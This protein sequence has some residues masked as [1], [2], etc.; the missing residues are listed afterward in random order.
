M[1]TTL[2]HLKEQYLGSDSELANQTIDGLKRHFP[3]VTQREFFE[4]VEPQEWY[5][6]AGDYVEYAVLGAFLS[7]GLAFLAVFS[8]FYI[9]ILIGGGLVAI[10]G[11]IVFLVG[12]VI[13]LTYLVAWVL[14]ETGAIDHSYIDTTL[15][16]VFDDWIESLGAVEWVRIPI[17]YMEYLVTVF[18]G[19]DEFDASDDRFRQMFML[20]ATP[21]LWQ[22]MMFLCPFIV[23]I[24][25]IVMIMYWVDPTLFAHEVYI[26]EHDMEIDEDDKWIK[27]MI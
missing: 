12:S 2:E 4:L 22:L 27:F 20:L 10:V 24:Q 8:E 26:W 23:V 5:E 14:E 11:S 18:L 25:P 21:W 13:G 15:N 9:E 19:L 16:V 3:R 7:V 1:I 6:E 17:I